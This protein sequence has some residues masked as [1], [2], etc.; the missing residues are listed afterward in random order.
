MSPADRA[1]AAQKLLDDPLARELLDTIERDAVEAM[2]AAADDT[3]RREARDTV[4]TVRKLR[5]ALHMM[6]T[7]HQEAKRARPAVA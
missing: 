5:T 7:A 1:L 3:S 6:M 2:L 4:T